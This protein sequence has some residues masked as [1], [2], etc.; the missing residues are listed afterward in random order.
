MHRS[1]HDTDAIYMHPQCQRADRVDP[2]DRSSALFLNKMVM[3]K[4][5]RELEADPEVDLASK[6]PSTYASRLAG[7]KS[8]GSWASHHYALVVKLKLTS[9]SSFLGQATSTASQDRYFA[10][11]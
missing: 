1:S 4:L 3:R 8:D 10:V 11:S 5:Q 9:C 7:R 6:I 2:V